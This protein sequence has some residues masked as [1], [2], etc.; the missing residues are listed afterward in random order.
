[1]Y[2]HG[3]CQCAWGGVKDSG[4]GRAHS[5]FG[6]YECVNVKTVV[7]EPGVVRNFWWHPYDETLGRAVKATAKLLYG[8]ERDRD[9]ALREGAKPLGTVIGRTLRTLHRS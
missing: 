9:A 8:R 5:K 6:L 3:A 1:M 2:S 7:W 4:L